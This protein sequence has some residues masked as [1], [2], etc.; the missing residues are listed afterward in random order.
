MTLI[1]VQDDGNGLPSDFDHRQS[2]SL[3]MQLVSMLAEQLG[4]SLE[5]DVSAGTCFTITFPTNGQ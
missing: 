4:G 1:R 2:N 3:G 5:V